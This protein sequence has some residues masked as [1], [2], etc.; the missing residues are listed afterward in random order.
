MLTVCFVT[1]RCTPQTPSHDWEEGWGLYL[2]CWKPQCPYLD[3]DS[4]RV[5]NPFKE[6]IHC[7][8]CTIALV[9]YASLN[10][11]QHNIFQRHRA[12]HTN[13]AGFQWCFH[14]SLKLPCFLCNDVAFLWADRKCGHCPCFQ[15]WVSWFFKRQRHFPGVQ[16]VSANLDVTGGF[17]YHLN[18][19]FDTE[20]AHLFLE[21]WIVDRRIIHVKC[22]F[23]VK[24]GTI[25]QS[26]VINTFVLSTIQEGQTLPWEF[27]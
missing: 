7:V 5:P 6:T 21:N 15:E 10:R 9:A 20:L 4:L 17:L 18:E 2:I 11:T 13:S 12:K 16:L 19:T 14:D 24:F 1:N 25:V 26:T 22:D 23:W 3:N 27:Q 8:W